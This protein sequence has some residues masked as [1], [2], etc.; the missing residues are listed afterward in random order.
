MLCGLGPEYDSLVTSITTRVDSITPADLYAYMLSFENRYEHNTAT[1]K[2]PAANN[3]SRIQSRGSGN[4]GGNRGGGRSNRGRSGGRNSGGRGGNGGQSSHSGSGGNGEP[5]QVCG[6]LGRMVLRCWH[7]FDRSYQ[8]DETKV[9]AAAV[10]GSY[11]V[12]PNW[13]AD[14]G[15]TD[16]ITNDLERMTLQDR[17]NGN[18][19][20]QTASGSGMSIAH[21]GNSVITT[22]ARPLLL[23]NILHVP[24]INRHLLSIHRL[25]SDN[26]ASAEFHPHCF[27]VKDQTTRNILLKGRCKDGL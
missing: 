17:Y 3:V 25:V 13:Y 12:D 23:K 16:H 19:Q 21:V 15:A 9:A 5:C 6:K 18:D 24:K 7:R 20:V 26:H 14:S 1:Y 2:V 4:S 10:T 27:L 11:A 8:P 22:A